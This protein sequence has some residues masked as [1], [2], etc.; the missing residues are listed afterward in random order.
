MT[1]I[2]SKLVNEEVNKK[3]TNCDDVLRYKIVILLNNIK[4]WIF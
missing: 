1:D 3:F 4:N 2:I